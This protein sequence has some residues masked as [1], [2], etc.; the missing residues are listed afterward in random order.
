MTLTEF[1][2]LA[3]EERALRLWDDGNLIGATDHGEG[4]S[5]FYTLYDFYVEVHHTNDGTG[6]V[7]I[8]PFKLG[9]RLDGICSVI[10]LPEI[11]FH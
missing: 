4:R 3:I 10:N 1:N 6:I 2:T 8:V 5:A 11:L 7:T 9:P